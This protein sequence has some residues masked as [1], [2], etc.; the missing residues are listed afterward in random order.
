MPSVKHKAIRGQVI[1]FQKY[2]HLLWE[3][4]IAEFFCR[5]VDGNPGHIQACRI[6]ITQGAQGV[7]QHYAA[8]HTHH[9]GFFQNRQEDSGRDGSA[10]CMVPSC[11]RFKA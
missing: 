10:D 4:G 7:T 6:P 3:F 1:P 5:H 2:Q 9:P 8:E 11:Q